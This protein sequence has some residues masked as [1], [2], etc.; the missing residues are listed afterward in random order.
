MSP[1]EVI[2][3]GHEAIFTLLAVGSPI[4]GSALAVGL[5]V[6]LFQ[7]LTQM[8]EMTLSFVPKIAVMALALFVFLPYMM[9]TLVS[10]GERMFERIAGI[11]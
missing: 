6:S 5:V 7:A 1:V 10:F 11:G 9:S 8:Q 3:I 4:L 2:G